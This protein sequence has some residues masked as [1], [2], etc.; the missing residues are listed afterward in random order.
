MTLSELVAKL[1]S[2]AETSLL[3]Q[4]ELTP[5]ALETAASEAMEL[6]ENKPIPTTMLLDLAM[7]R[8]M[9]LLKVEPTELAIQLATQAIKKAGSLKVDDGGEVVSGSDAIAYG[10]RFSLWNPL[11]DELNWK[12]SQDAL[13]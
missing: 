6:T 9:L 10:E 8:L 5:Q 1:Q 13:G 7:L 12:E 2:R 3:N 11:G 4:A